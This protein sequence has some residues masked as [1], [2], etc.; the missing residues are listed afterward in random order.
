MKKVTGTNKI[1]TIKKTRAT[2]SGSKLNDWVSKPRNRSICLSVYRTSLKVNPFRTNFLGGSFVYIGI[3]EYPVRV[4]QYDMND[5][6]ID[7]VATFPKLKSSIHSNP[8]N[9]ENQQMQQATFW[10]ELEQDK[11]MELNK[12]RSIQRTKTKVKRYVIHKNMKYMWTLTFSKK[13]IT[14]LSSKGEKKYDTGV[15]A[16]AWKLWTNFI[17]RCHRAG[18]RFD[19]IVTIEVQEKRLEKYGEKV[20]HFHFATNRNLPIDKSKAKKQSVSAGLLSL[21]GHGRIDVQKQKSKKKFANVYLMK[22]IT[23]MFDVCKGAQRY[24]CSE[25]MQ[26]PQVNLYF[27]SE[28]ELDLYVHDLAQKAGLRIFKEYFPLSNGHNE[29]LFYGVTPRED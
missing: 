2:N 1:L 11:K 10:N 12:E 17:Q 4:K 29:I 24:R 14:V 15:L 20:Y 3:E 16:D 21:W 5:Q 23:K 25:N 26:I 6:F 9:P 8:D 7:I 19:Y 22:Y 28:M 27:R 13:Y 18:L